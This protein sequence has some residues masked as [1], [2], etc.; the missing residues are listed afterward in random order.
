MCFSLYVSLWQYVLHK[1]KQVAY[2]FFTFCI[3]ISWQCTTPERRDT[4]LKTYILWVWDDS[5][6]VI[7]TELVN[8]IS[9]NGILLLTDETVIYNSSICTGVILLSS[10]LCKFILLYIQSNRMDKK[11]QN[12]T[13]KKAINFCSTSTWSH[14][15]VGSFVRD[16]GR[17]YLRTYRTETIYTCPWCF[18]FFACTCTYMCVLLYWT[19]IESIEN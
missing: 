10:F 4:S 1:L 8:S 11:K 2:F 14:K 19:S 9:F 16:E 7:R 12:K 5:R 6:E 15:C 13:K 18:D 3:Q 17:S